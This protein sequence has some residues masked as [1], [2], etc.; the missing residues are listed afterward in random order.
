MIKLRNPILQVK[1]YYNSTANQIKQDLFDNGP[2]SVAV[3]SLHSSFLNAGSSG[4]INCEKASEWVDHAV[5]LVGYT[6]T[7]WIIKNSWGPNWG[8]NGF[9]YIPMNGPDCG[10]KKWITLMVVEKS[11]PD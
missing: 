2:V 6:A 4:I 8:D 9:G 10:I 7:H 11:L 1:N 3:A 5:L